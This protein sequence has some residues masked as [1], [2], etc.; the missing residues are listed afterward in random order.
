MV[1][2]A[3]FEL[4]SASY[5]IDQKNQT[6]YLELAESIGLAK[7]D[8]NSLD[9]IN[10][11]SYGFGHLIKDIIKKY[12]IKKMII[13][14]G[15][16]ATSDLG[17]GML[18]A[19]GVEFIDQDGFLIKKMNNAKLMRVRKIKTKAFEKLIK[20]IEFIT[21]TDVV[22]LLLGKKGAIMTFASQKGAKQNQLFMMEENI[23]HIFKL[24]K[25]QKK[26]QIADF[27]GAGAAGG[28]GFTMKYFFHSKIASGIDQ[29]LEMIDFKTLVKTYDVIIT[30]E[31]KFDKQSLDGKVFSGI[32]K[33]QPQRLIVIC[34]QNQ[35][36]KKDEEIY[37]IVPTVASL[38]E[39]F[40]DPVL[41]LQKLLP[42]IKIK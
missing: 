20:G 4:T 40:K 2:N 36:K 22:N 12:S 33:Y 19:L 21:L 26:Q 24:L 31:G 38:E 1:E 7:V 18:E 23:K 29:I 6:A 15:G 3:N 17:C 41:A 25:Y 27:A 10:A 35:L 5:I 16:S 11:S 34:G 13:G 42:F 14:I 32:K 28:I 39:S 30:G 37:A 9:A 8:K